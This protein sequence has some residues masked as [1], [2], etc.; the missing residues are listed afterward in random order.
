MQ[1]D[2]PV[3]AISVHGVNGAW[4]VL[5]LGLFADGTY[6]EGWNGTHWYKIG[7]AL[8]WFD[9][10]LSTDEIAKMATNLHLTPDKIAETGVTGLFYGNWSQFFA[11]CIGV[12]AN[13]IWVFASAYAFFWVI[14]KLIGN[15]VKPAVEL[16]GLDV[17]EMGVLGYINEDPKTPEGHVS[18]AGGAAPGRA[19]TRRSQALHRGRGRRQP[20]RS[21][22]RLGNRVRTQR[23]QAV[24]GLL[25]GLSR[26]DDV[27]RQPLPIPRGR[28]RSGQ[29]EPGAASQTVPANEIRQRSRRGGA[30]TAWHETSRDRQ[31]AGRRPL[32]DG[33][34][35][36]PD[37][38]RRCRG[39]MIL[40]DATPAAT[41]QALAL[42]V[43]AVLPFALL[44]LAVAVMPLAAEPFWRKNRNKAL[45]AALLAAPVVVFLLC[46]GPATGWRSTDALLHEVGQYGS[47]IILLASLYTISGGIVLRGPTHPSATANTLF[48]LGGAVLANLIGTTGASILLIR[49]VLQLNRGRRYG[50]HV[51]VFFIFI[52][53]NVGGL[54]TPLGDPPLF[55]GF[56][57]GV[58]F[59][60]TLTLLP[61]WLI[62][63]G[64]LLAVFCVW[65]ALSL[66]RE[67]RLTALEHRPTRPLRLQGL[68]NVVFLLGVAIAVLMQSPKLGSLCGTWLSQFVPCGPLTLVSP[69]G[70]ALMAAMALLSLAL[71]PRAVRRANEFSLGRDRRGRRAVR[72]HLRHHDARPGVA[73]EQGPRFGLTQPWE[74]FWLSGRSR[75]SSTTRP[76]T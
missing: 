26:H 37:N 58:D 46:I 27:Q 7:D 73:R 33:R 6:G 11:E 22:D 30:L 42:P 20:R 68:Y 3:G 55:L 50:A 71:T 41:E 15:R 64:V 57:N 14:E 56:L 52:V 76:P 29:D 2:D 36:S 43:W 16:Q 17:P 47:F 39:L 49:P 54:L 69:W 13:F 60:W 8:K 62:A 19:A 72:R 23:Q 25:G 18:G 61:Q 34:G 74:F 75:P 45:V 59:L 32:P 66:R 24:A 70:E 65:D 31:G 5:S 63:N 1:V 12:A 28:R 38:P 9:H 67:P 51:P 4:G 44:L 35:S 40:A 48:L 21:D 53:S 10:A